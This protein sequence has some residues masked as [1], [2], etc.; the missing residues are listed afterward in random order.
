MNATPPALSA[1]LLS[2]A[3]SDHPRREYPALPGQ[4]N[5]LRAGV[6]VPLS[7]RSDVGPTVVA[8]VRPKTMR[9][10]AGEVCFP[11]GRPEA[12]DKNLFATALREAR[13]EVGIEGARL[14]GQLSSVP[15]YTSN[16]R[17][18]PFVAEV[19]DGPLR[20]NPGEVA[21][22]LIVSLAKELDCEW[23][24]AIPWSQSGQTLLSPVFT[25]GPHVMY[26]G[27]A[28]VFYELL[29]V[30]AKALGQDAPPLRPGRYS[31]DELLP[32]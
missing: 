13:E 4:T 8:T 3:L 26:G 25:L 14:L 32:R 28:H 24:D 27:T 16:Y 31:W 22:V 7:W 5:H 15:L 2:D 1:Q 11:G 19:P 29:L 30:A 12:A 18:E 20:P 9:A 17:L 21:E 23:I 6:L 10:H